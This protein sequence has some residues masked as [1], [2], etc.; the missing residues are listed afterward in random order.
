MPT[1]ITLKMHTKHGRAAAYLADGS[2][3]PII[4]KDGRKA[5]AWAH[6]HQNLFESAPGAVV[7]RGRFGGISAP[8]E[9]ELLEMLGSDRRAWCRKTPKVKER[10]CS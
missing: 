1:I 2:G 6:M 3:E 8:D 10:G 9:S 4:F 7:L 5:L